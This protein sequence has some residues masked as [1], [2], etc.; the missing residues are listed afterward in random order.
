MSIRD[1]ATS[2]RWRIIS[3]IVL[4]VFTALTAV[5]YI[6][7]AVRQSEIYEAANLTVTQEVQEFQ[8]FT[9]EGTGSTSS[10]GYNDPAHLLEVYLS[11]QIPANNEFLFGIAGN[12]FIAQ[13]LSKESRVTTT[14]ELGKTDPII[15]E[16]IN[17]PDSAG[18]ITHLEPYSIHWG[19][20]EL[21]VEGST[22]KNYFAILAFTQSAH[23]DL[24]AQNQVL[25]LIGA[26]AL[27][28]AVLVAW[29]ISG[30]IIR[31]VQQVDDVARS[32]A[33]SNDLSQR[34]PVS[35]NDEIARLSATFNTMLDRIDEA[36]KTQRQFVDDAGHELRTPITVVR[37][38][39]E[40]LESSN[41][42]Q[43]A[44]SIEICMAELD[45]M[46]RMVNDMLTLAVVDAGSAEFIAKKPTDVSELTIDIDDKAF[47]LSGGRTKVTSIA[48]G[49]VDLDPQRITEAILELVR[50]AT[51]YSTPE[52]PITIS[53]HKDDKNLTLSVHNVGTPIPEAEMFKLFQRFHRG[54]TQAV[55]ASAH[56]TN[57]TSS[58]STNQQS[59]KSTSS[60]SSTP[61][62][63]RLGK[64]A[65]LGLSIVQAIAHAHGGRVD[66]LSDKSGTTFSAIIPVEST[67]SIKTES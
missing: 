63:N 19:K 48:E 39:L 5:I 13:D 7:D 8:R 67:E 22:D 53:S 47:V 14:R 21:G 50:N 56:S 25:I 43:R 40:L 64:G 33:D 46:T 30:Q 60:A 42:E 32:I 4:V 36:Y 57:N 61:A 58:N 26:I 27:I 65:G 51:K 37:G 1:N 2:L 17:S 15:Q 66:A 10:Q 9:V 62:H 24:R 16:V 34:V 3:W 29:F 6:T 18:V 20:V 59:D 54:D 55:P 41:P 23:E 49:E 12:G 52:T 31:P 35:G 45:R 38:N 44:R 11:S 28:I